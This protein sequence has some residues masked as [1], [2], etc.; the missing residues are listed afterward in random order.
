MESFI[1]F[2]API[3]A[4]VGLIVAFCL[5]SWIG[6]ADEGT[7]RRMKEIAGFIREGAMA[8]LR[9]EY[10]TMV[11]VIVVLFLL[12]GFGLQNWTTAVLYVIG[13]LLSV[14]A[15]FFGMNVA[16]KGNVR[17]A[18]AAKEAG[19]PKALKSRSDRVRLWDFA[20]QVL[21]C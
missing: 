20:Y 18:N 16:T 5:A 4:V 7:D 1:S 9:R 19:M 11:I 12:I 3:A 17:T 14:L 13:A 15:G 10:K 8:F 6:K 2:V 21:D